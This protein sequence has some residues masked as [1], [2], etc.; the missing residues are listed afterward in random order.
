MR[1]QRGRDR[2]QVDGH[3]HKGTFGET[4]AALARW[5]ALHAVHQRI[6]AIMG[7]ERA[8]AAQAARAAVKEGA[9]DRIK[10]R[11]PPVPVGLGPLVVAFLAQGLLIVVEEQAVPGQEVGGAVDGEGLVHVHDDEVVVAGLGAGHLDGIVSGGK[12]G[13]AVDCFGVLYAFLWGEG[14]PVVVLAQGT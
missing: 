8:V 13:Q 14:M 12:G 4:P 2:A 9:V 10:G 11:L 3:V 6:G 7:H 5:D 1:G